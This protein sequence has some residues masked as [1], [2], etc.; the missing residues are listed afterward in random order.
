M[1]IILF[2]NIYD[3]EDSRNYFDIIIKSNIIDL[4]YIQLV[5]ASNKM[6]III[7]ILW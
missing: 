1:F 3:N 7:I 4:N 6:L 2:M 5:N